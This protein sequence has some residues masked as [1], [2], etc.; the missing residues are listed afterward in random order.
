MNKPT[1]VKGNQLKPSWYK[2]KYF[3]AKWINDMLNVVSRKTGGKAFTISK[4]AGIIVIPV[5]IR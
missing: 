4:N 3:S 2:G 5:V 1:R